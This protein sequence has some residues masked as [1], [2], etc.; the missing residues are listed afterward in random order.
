M[1]AGLIALGV[2]ALLALVAL[3]NSVQIV[4]QAQAAVIERWGRYL[5]TLDAG[6]HTIVPF[7]DRRRRLVDLREQVVAFPPQPVITVDNVT[8]SID[9]VFYLTVIDPVRATYGVANLLDAI[10]QLTITTLRNVIGALSLD[11]VL[12]SRDHINAD[13]REVLD[14]ATERWGIRV[15]RIELKSIDPPASIQQA[16]EKQMRAERDKR[17][18]ILT[19]EGEK[20]AAI[21]TAEGDRQA[22]ILRAEAEQQSEVLNA[23]GDRQA[24]VLRA[25]GDAEAIRRV[26]EA[27]H[28]GR[29][30][31]EVLAYAYLQVLPEVA[32]GQATKLLM[33]PS[34]ALAGIAAAT[35]L[36]AGLQMG[37][38]AAAGGQAAS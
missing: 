21:L 31:P 23:E 3:G 27:I 30:T 1:T 2:V 15:N 9:T 17:A 11:Q 7:I 22:R 33:V 19:A 18:A 37:N 13:L 24:K 10:E 35:A 32:D 14:E 4:P 16:M 34:D 29:A 8:I 36:G 25:D 28:E 5:R 6:L 38:G 26:F 12:T 20:Q